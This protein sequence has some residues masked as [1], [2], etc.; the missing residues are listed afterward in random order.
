ME[1]SFGS[2]RSQPMAIIYSKTAQGQQEIETRAR[3]L[4]PR[5]RSTLILVDGKRSD[6]E[7]G[8]LVPNADE[9][10]QALLDAQMI[11]A[12]GGS[13]TKSAAAPP[14]AA[15][16]AAPADGPVEDIMA[17]RRDAVRAVNDLLGPEAEALA[18]RMERATDAEQMRVALER[19]VTYI[20]NVRGGGAAAQFAARF[21][22]PAG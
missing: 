16:D 15:A 5:L 3:R 21:L 8:K 9:V 4:P 6:E 7:L 1:V 19:A 18:L 20:A 22:K 14:P 11:E 13:P 12:V 10:L 17:L 2:L